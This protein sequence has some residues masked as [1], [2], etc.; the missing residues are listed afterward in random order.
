MT[1][2]PLKLQLMNGKQVE[3]SEPEF[4]EFISDVMV[5]NPQW[6]NSQLLEEVEVTRY[7][8]NEATT[9]D[10]KKVIRYILVYQEN[11]ALTAYLFIK[12]NDQKEADTSK[13]YN[14]E[15]LMK[16]R[17]L[18]SLANTDKLNILNRI[19][20]RMENLCMESGAD[21]I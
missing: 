13:K 14:I 4:D 16:L 10:L 7:L 6:R 12:V 2:F 15:T 18:K 3:L 11:L 21:P 17:S 8:K 9:E 19:A 5:P 1:T 20:H